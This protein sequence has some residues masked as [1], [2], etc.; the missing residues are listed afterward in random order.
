MS[1][2]KGNVVPTHIRDQARKVAQHEMGH[3]VMARVMGF[4]TDGVS[5]E[6]RHNGHLG[7]AT[8]QL[9][10]SLRSLDD[11]SS[12]L[13]RRVLVL[14]AGAMA[15]TLHPAHIP[16]SGV[17]QE[18]A[19]KILNEGLG[20]EQDYA[21]AREAILL[22]RNIEHPGTLEEGDVQQELNELAQSLW[23]RTVEVVELL[24]STIV[25]VAGALTERLHS[26]GPR[27]PYVAA[28]SKDD[29][30]EIPNLMELPSLKP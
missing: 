14:Y 10:E 16:K 23:D 26:A 20:A 11:V 18:M 17:D 13:K 24:E 15:E 6:I 25:G 30:E 27:E 28:F 1:R 22:L 9:S 5:I 2:I 8:V 19:V 29:L 21:K 12:Y 3:Y 7:G 4:V